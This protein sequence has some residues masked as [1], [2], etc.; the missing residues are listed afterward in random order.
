[1]PNVKS[2]KKYVG[3]YY[4]ES[5]V[6]R[7]RERPDRIYWVSFREARTGK[8]RWERCGWASDGVT[9]ESAQR[10][11]YRLLEKD[12]TGKYK[13]K[14]VRRVE[15]MTFGELIEKHYLP[16]TDENKKRSHDRSRYTIWLKP[17]LA[18]KALIEIA[19]LDL[20]RIKKDMRKAGKSDATIA[21]ALKVVRQAYNK[22]IAW[23]LWQGENP[24]KGVT[25]PKLDNARQRFFSHDEAADLLKALQEQDPQ[26]AR[27]A[28]LS[29]YSGLR[30]GEVFNLTWAN[31]DHSHGIIHVLDAKSGERPVFITDPIRE[32]LDELPPGDPD[33]PLFKTK[34]GDRVVWLSKAFRKVVDSLKMN[35]G[36]SDPR[37]R[38]TFHTLRHTYASWAVMA[39][40]PLYQVGKALGHKTLT[41]TQRYSHL[42][43]ES[44][45]A[46][47]EAVANSVGTKKADKNKEI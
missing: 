13:P 35:E 15:Q 29:L 14:R 9:P 28:K 42:S 20:E 24:C 39:G 38:V 22:A 40:V 5:Q 23:G 41:M 47:F 1:M 18:K 3:V 7:W 4:S 25:F 32:V 45:R 17:K 44:Q 26:T 16:W 27:V 11:R 2:I 36:I 30:L 10:I 46:V 8:L 6:R 37:E 19:P 31:I 12:R 43:T 33:E 34:R 21:H